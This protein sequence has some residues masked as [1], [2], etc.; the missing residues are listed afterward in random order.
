MVDTDKIALTY[1]TQCDILS[2]SLSV[3]L[4]FFPH[5]FF[6]RSIFPLNYFLFTELETQRPC[7]AR[8]YYHGCTCTLIYELY[9]DGLACICTNYIKR[10]TGRL[11]PRDFSF[12]IKK[13][14]KKKKDK[15]RYNLSRTTNLSE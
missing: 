3:F 7:I 14:R 15:N 11:H 1:Q 5:P 6:S 2:I 10:E 8:I 4:S 13:K 12:K 9:R